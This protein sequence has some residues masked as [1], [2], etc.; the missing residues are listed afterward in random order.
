MA[1]HVDK[2]MVAGKFKAKPTIILV[3]K[4]VITNNAPD[5]ANPIAPSN[6]FALFISPTGITNADFKYF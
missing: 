2:P 1:R 5:G 4:K 6:F 3:S